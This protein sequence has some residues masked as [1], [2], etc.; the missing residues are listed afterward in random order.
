MEEIKKSIFENISIANQK[1]ST[2]KIVEANKRNFLI[3]AIRANA[4]IVQLFGGGSNISKEFRRYIEVFRRPKGFDIDLTK[5]FLDRLNYLSI[6]L[7]DFNSSNTPIPYSQHSII[8]TTNNIFIIHGHD[9]LNTHRLFNLIQNDFSLNPIAIFMKPG[10]SK[11]ILDKFEDEASVCSFAFALFSKD[12]ELIKPNEK[13][14]QARPNVIFESG[15]F[16]SRLGKDRI[17]L[18]LQNDVKIHSDLE[19]IS[20]IQFDLNIEEKY[21]DIRNELIAAKLI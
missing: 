3:M 13:Y 17:V 12:D 7:N 2:Y 10:Q 1:A 21:K 6:F 19:G 9:E 5:E 18:L 16:T 15:W 14:F 8:P 4:E 20:R 11:I